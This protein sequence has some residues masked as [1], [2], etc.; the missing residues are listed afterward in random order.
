MT[1][2]ETM[3]QKKFEQYPSLYYITISVVREKML[4]IETAIFF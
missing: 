3:E 1:F 2:N 4:K